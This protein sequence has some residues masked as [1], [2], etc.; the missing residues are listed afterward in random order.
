MFRRHACQVIL[1]FTLF[2]FVGLVVNG[3]GVIDPVEALSSP[4]HISAT[5]GSS[6]WLHWNYTYTGDGPSGPHLTLTY[7]EQI[8][9]FNSTF[10]PTIQ[11]VAKRTGASGALALES[12]VPAPFNDKVEVMQSND[13]LVIHRIQYNDS[14]YQFSSNVK[15]DSNIGGAILSNS[16]ELKPIVSITVNGMNLFQSF[17]LQ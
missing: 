14:I 16:Y 9:G 2:L 8:I 11:I 7:R 5:K 4:S 6:V 17:V 10:Q 1:I 13:T 15:V 12:S 3:Q